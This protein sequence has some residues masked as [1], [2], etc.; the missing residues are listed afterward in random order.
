MYLFLGRII[1]VISDVGL[2]IIEITQKEV[3]TS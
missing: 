3:C 1:I 2:E